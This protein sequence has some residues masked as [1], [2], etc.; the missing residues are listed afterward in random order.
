MKHMTPRR[1]LMLAALAVVIA[2]KSVS[3]DGGSFDFGG[4]LGCE[5]GGINS[6]PIGAYPVEEK[7]SN[8]G[9]LRITQSGFQFVEQ[10]AVGLIEAALGGSLS[11]PLPE[12]SAIGCTYC[13]GGCQLELNIANVRINPLVPDKLEVKIWL[14]SDTAITIPFECLGF[15][16]CDVNIDTR[17]T[18]MLVTILILM[19]I[20]GETRQLDLIVNEPQFDLS[21]ININMSGLCDFIPGIDTII[22]FLKDSVLGP[23][24]AP[25]IRDAVKEAVEGFKCAQCDADKPC[26][27]PYGYG[28]ACDDKGV[29][30]KPNNDCQLQPL[31]IE[32]EVDVGA[33]AASMLPG[34]QAK[35]WLSLA[36]GGR[37]Q[38]MDGGLEIGM[39]GGSMVPPDNPDPCTEK[40][41]YPVVGN[42]PAIPLTNFNTH[43]TPP[44]RYHMGIGLREEL[45]DQAGFTLQ[46]SG[47]LCLTID[48]S[49]PS[50]GK[51][52][53]LSNFALLLPSIN[54]YTHGED[55]ASAIMLE[56]GEQPPDFTILDGATAFPETPEVDVGLRIS[57]RDLKLN[58]YGLVEERFLRLF[59]LQTDITITA[60][61]DTMD[62]SI[63]PI[64]GLDNVVLSNFRVP[65]SILSADPAEMAESLEGLIGGLLSQ[66]PL[67]PLEPIE[68]PGIDID[69]DGVYDL[70]IQLQMAA[71]EVPK[72]TGAPT[73]YSGLVIYAEL[74][75][76]AGGGRPVP[77]F[78]AE[79]DA[80]VVDVFMPTAE[81]YVQ[82]GRLP[83]ATLA[84]SGLDADRSANRLEYQFA[85]DNGGWSPWS[86]DPNPTISTRWLA[87]Q[88]K[89][90]IKIRARD[91]RYKNSIDR[92]PA[93]VEMTTDFT[94]PTA[95]LMR[96]GSRVRVEARDNITAAG[97]LRVRH[98]LN[99]GAWSPWSGDGTIDLAKVNRFPV[100][101]EA[102]VKDRA[103][104]VA[105]VSKRF[106]RATIEPVVAKRSAG[107]SGL[108]DGEAP[109][110]CSAAQPLGWL[111]W[112]FLAPLA[113]LR[114]R[115]KLAA[116]AGA[117]AVAMLLV[118]GCGSGSA[119]RACVNNTDCGIGQI[120]EN[121]Q[122]KDV[123]DI[124][125]DIDCDADED[126]P[127]GYVC[128][129]DLGKCV[130]E[131]SADGDKENGDVADGDDDSIE[132]PDCVDGKCPDCY[133]CNRRTDKCKLQ[134][135]DP[136]CTNPALAPAPCTDQKNDAC[137]V[138]MVDESDGPNVCDVPR[139]TSNENKETL[140]AECAC[141]APECE[142]LKKPLAC[143]E[144]TGVCYCAD[145][146][147]GPCAENA[148]CCE[149]T[150]LCTDCPAWCEGVACEPGFAPGGCDPMTDPGCEVF[151]G[152]QPWTPCVNW[153]KDACAFTGVG[154]PGHPSCECEEK[155]PLPFGRHGRYNDIGVHENTDVWVAAYNETYGDLVV[156]HA[157]AAE[158]FEY[159]I[160]LETADWTFLDGV[161]D[162]APT[163]G[164][165]GPRG[166]IKTPGPDVGKYVSLAVASDGMPRIAYQDADNGDLLFMYASPA[167][168][169]GGRNGGDETLAGVTWTKIVVD[170]FGDTG[171]Y[172]DMYLDA[173]DRPVIAYMMAKG[174]EDAP[175]AGT[176]A[177]KLAMATTAA[178]AGPEDFVFAAVD[179]AP[180]G[181][182]YCADEAGCTFLKKVTFG[183]GVNPSLNVMPSGELW[184]FYYHHTSYEQLL[185]ADDNPYMDNVKKGLLM[186]A[187]TA[188]PDPATLAAATF[189]RDAFMG[190]PGT[191]VVGDVGLY[192][193]FDV[194]ETTGWYALSFSN[195]GANQ[196]QFVYDMGGGLKLRT[197]DD[198][199]RRDRQGRKYRAW[200][201]A[202]NSLSID[203]SGYIRILYQDQSQGMLMY[204]SEQCY[205]DTCNDRTQESY[206]EKNLRVDLGTGNAE[207]WG[208]C[209]GFYNAQALV[210]GMTSILSTYD[211]D[212]HG[213][214]IIMEL[215]VHG[216]PKF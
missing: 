141:R 66:I 13:G 17:N 150:D 54:Y 46:N 211:V 116:A 163:A 158:L 118:A 55:V 203:Q 72:S 121:G 192:H 170:A 65:Y 143:N 58:V 139:C 144:A 28:V 135:C 61:L 154:R 62:F 93:V 194:I 177:L 186:R 112:L 20:D 202:D 179:T 117:L 29:C 21:Q 185:D 206:T 190:A 82:E 127:L 80:E 209:G 105:N 119:G 153:D 85:I 22:N 34:L 14:S 52:L 38:V 3:C 120:C 39:F 188:P 136:N 56:P 95:R 33:L 138:C 182:P 108:V 64:F 204:Y 162:E 96:D 142:T 71:P 40:I 91:A 86:N 90:A 137:A 78:V 126:C 87:W 12:G 15:L 88:G 173:Q 24:V 70:F 107:G 216:A 178:P 201:G 101:M 152:D 4:C 129:L 214:D 51:Y 97:D 69:S 205:L 207:E 74:L 98:R 123:G 161:P 174:P 43:F 42:L 8:L 134:A 36:A 6:L 148:L 199:N 26:S 48:D 168:P 47:L 59:T 124:D 68:L 103:G 213:T 50:V 76:S 167:A 84:L 196:L 189:T 208:I 169:G 140:A 193:S 2:L 183:T 94:A 106:E 184:I 195:A 10:N 89:H 81:E 30:R 99:G 77:P 92:T 198:G 19:Y 63:Q 75:Q 115:V 128:N 49:M 200:V 133:Y 187:R 104:Y 16:G 149:P 7:I 157:P 191:P 159:R 212:L 181:E 156:A 102:Q 171:Y 122:C 5:G 44:Q 151:V 35:M 41:A 175:E 130:P 132:E 109:Q 114:R 83:A 215:Q 113:L 180:V 155:P 1:I 110:G 111:L 67:D 23:I 125:I 147:G 210:G 57:I 100:E 165:S 197:A 172:V 11:F 9:Q 131:D 60:G 146:C 32:A 160:Y 25:M 18:P 73:E 45:L 79:T 164:P 166:G 27:D 145:P 37:A 31:G 53:A 176:S